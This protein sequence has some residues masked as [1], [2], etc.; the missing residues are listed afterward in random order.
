MAKR[1]ID[2]ELFKDPWFYNLK[3]AD[4][5][6]WIYLFTNCDH[7]GIWKENLKLAQSSVGGKFDINQMNN[8]K[9]RLIKIDHDSYFLPDF[10][11]YQYPHLSPDSNSKVYVSVINRLKEK[12]LWDESKGYVRVRQG[13][14]KGCQRVL[15][16]YKDKD[17]DKDKDK[18]K[19]IKIKY[20]EFV[21]MTEIEYKKLVKIYEEEFTKACIDRLNTY[22][23]STGKK[24]K[25]HYYTI[26]RWVVDAELK[27]GE[28]EK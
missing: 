27:T 24:Y 22:L 14:G 15:D 23:G 5:A 4:K 8:E 12:N 11:E 9:L 2:S 1:F 16:I 26:L 18:N 10:I 19:D 17:K 21:L 3:P 6:F 20:G 7:A 13:L 28:W 25:S